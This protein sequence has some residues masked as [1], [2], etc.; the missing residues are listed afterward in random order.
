MIFSKKITFCA[1]DKEMVNIWRHPKPASRFI[2]DEFKKLSRFYEGNLHDPTIK[3]C[4]PFLDSM[5]AGYIIQFDQD[6][7]IDPKD[8]DFSVTP[9]NREEGGIDYHNKTQLP[10]KWHSTTGQAA[11]KFINKW[12]I[13][14]PPGYSCL[15]V[16]PM[17]RLET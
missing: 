9:A 10:E 3:T 8:T 2:P 15:F 4:M 14:T 17:N 6:Y 12:L 11:G 1:I 7:V 13:K 5:T 16:K